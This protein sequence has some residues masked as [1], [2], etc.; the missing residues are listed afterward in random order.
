MR[1]LETNKRIA[2][3]KTWNL[4]NLVF[5]S[6]MDIIDRLSKKQQDLLCKADYINR[7]SSMCISNKSHMLVIAKECLGERKTKKRDVE[8]KV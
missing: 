4:K 8:H 2:K 7:Y 5:E 3:I 6:E 1:I